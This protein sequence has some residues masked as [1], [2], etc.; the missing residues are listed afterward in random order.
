[1][2]YSAKFEAVL[3][4]EILSQSQAINYSNAVDYLDTLNRGEKYSRNGILIILVSSLPLVTTFST[5]SS[6][7]VLRHTY[8][9]DR[10]HK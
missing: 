6:K 4:K 9:T 8:L 1:M 7:S 3:V 10:K 2:V 5:I